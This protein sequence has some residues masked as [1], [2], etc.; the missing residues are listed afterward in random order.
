M[1]LGLKHKHPIWR[2]PPQIGKERAPGVFKLSPWLSHPQK[3]LDDCLGPGEWGAGSFQAVCGGPQAGPTA[4][5]SPRAWAATQRGGSRQRPFCASLQGGSNPQR[6][7][8]APC[9]A[10]LFLPLKRLF[11]GSFETYRSAG[12]KGRVVPGVVRLQK[13]P[14][15]KRLILMSQLRASLAVSFRKSLSFMQRRKQMEITELI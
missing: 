15:K 4:P 7:H 1:L 13:V 3:R 2:A 11:A 5:P 10:L 14:K 8:F 9:P 6:S 12:K